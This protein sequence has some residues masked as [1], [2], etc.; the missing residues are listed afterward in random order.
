MISVNDGVCD[1]CDGSDEY[2]HPVQCK[3]H[4]EADRASR[5]KE[6]EEKIE[7]TKNGRPRVEGSHE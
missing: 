2:D 3:D 5:I 7:L 1:C 4:C 6:L